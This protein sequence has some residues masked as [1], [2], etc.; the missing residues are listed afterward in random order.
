MLDVLTIG[1]ALRDIIFHTDQTLIIE[2]P[3]DLLCQRLIAVEYG[4]KISSEKV[5]LSFGGGGLNTAVNFSTLG[6]KTGMLT[7]V[8]DDALSQEL[9]RH[10]RQHRIDPRWIQRIRR[11]PSGFSFVLVD[12]S[13]QEH[14]I[15]VRYGALSHLRWMLKTPPASWVYLSSLV[16]LQSNAITSGVNTWAKNKQ[17]QWAW[18]PGGPQLKQGK[19]GLNP[20]LKHLTV[21]NVNEDE[22]LELILSDIA[23]AREFRKRSSRIPA[24]K[25]LAQTLHAWGPK[26]VLITRGAKGAVV[27]EAKKLTT[28]GTRPIKRVDTTG[29]GDCYGST[30]VA[31]L[32]HFNGQVDRALALADAQ[33]SS[34]LQHIGA[35]AGLKTFQ[36]LK[37]DL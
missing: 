19:R 17:I 3:K 5:A 8:G 26:I 31:G 33:T 6:L 20:Y 13:T 7:A 1:S 37:K 14:A 30:F 36:Q 22:A 23:S 25:F 11:Q 9:F 2:T 21:L 16:G 32:I 29:A 27:V 35:H 15:F 34:L 24:W 18:N 4:A 28:I 10:I 12:T